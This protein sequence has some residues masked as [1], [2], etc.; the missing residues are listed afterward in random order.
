MEILNDIDIELPPD[1]DISIQCKEEGFL[2][3]QKLSYQSHCME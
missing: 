1:S 3:L 2:E